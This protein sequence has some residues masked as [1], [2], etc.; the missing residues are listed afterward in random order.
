MFIL[1]HQP[2]L[3]F[4][5]SPCRLF[6]ESF[7]RSRKITNLKFS[8]NSI[9]EKTT[10]LLQTTIPFY[11]ACTTTIKLWIPLPTIS[12]WFAPPL[13]SASTLNARM[14]LWHLLLPTIVTNTT[15]PTRILTLPHLANHLSRDARQQSFHSYLPR[16]CH[17]SVTNR[18]WTNDP[19]P[20]HADAHSWISLRTKTVNFQRT[21]CPFWQSQWFRLN[22]AEAMKKRFP[23]LDYRPAL[24]SYLA[25]PSRYLA[26]QRSMIRIS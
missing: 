23:H 19:I 8:N 10:L 25:F 4:Q 9:F 14:S 7:L 16:S 21:I 15:P 6:P 20:M 11:K 26:F 24:L 22:R 5:S 13:I 18:H 3:F 1:S 2:E 17:D 12:A